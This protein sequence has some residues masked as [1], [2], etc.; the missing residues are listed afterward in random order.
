MLEEAREMDEM[1][2]LRSQRSL[3]YRGTLCDLENRAR[4]ERSP[5]P[6]RPWE[7][8]VLLVADTV[9]VTANTRQEACSTI[10]P[11]RPSK[12]SP[13]AVPTTWRDPHKCSQSRRTPRIADPT[14]SKLA[15]TPVA[16]LTTA[17]A[18]IGK[19]AMALT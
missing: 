13:C 16:M 19:T 1:T 5:T 12:P 9:L 18:K 14:R 15:K 17:V 8:M 11:S 7:P 10:S 2:C 6:N 3:K 4:P